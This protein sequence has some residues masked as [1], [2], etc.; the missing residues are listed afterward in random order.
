MG[1]YVQLLDDG[2]ALAKARSVSAE[3]AQALDA[4]IEAAGT[5][6][7]DL[8]R[9]MKAREAAAAD[10]VLSLSQKLPFVFAGVMLLVIFWIASLL[11]GTVTDSLR[12]LEGSTRRIAAGD[13]TLMNPKRRYHD[14]FSDLSLAVNRMLLELGARDM[15][16]MKADRLAGVGMVTSGFAEQVSASFDTVAEHIDSF[17]ELSGG[18]GVRALRPDRRRVGGGAAGQG[19]RRQPVGVHRRGRVRA[20]AHQPPL[21]GRIEPAPARGADGAGEGDLR[22]RDPARHA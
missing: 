14:E 12:R 11:A 21:R 2:L 19:E 22:Q 5:D 10:R 4:Q 1:H 17:L 7:L 8:L 13:Y 16:V 20:L 3:Q 15:Q 18:Q 6:L 9:T